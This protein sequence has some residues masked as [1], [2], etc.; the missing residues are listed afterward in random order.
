[1]LKNF[2]LVQLLIF[3]SPIL[4]YFYIDN[5]FLIWSLIELQT[6]FFVLYVWNSTLRKENLIFFLLIQIFSSLGIFICIFLKRWSSFSIILNYFFLFFLI[7]KMGLMP[8]HQW[9]FRFA[10][11]LDFAGLFL[12]LGI[13][14]LIPLFLIIKNNNEVLQILFY[15]NII[16]SV[17][18]LFK[19][20]RYWS[21]IFFSSIFLTSL[22]FLILDLFNFSNFIIIV[23]IYNSLSFLLIKELKLHNIK[24]VFRM[25]PFNM[26]L[27]LFFIIIRILG[28]P[29]SLGFLLKILY[30]QTITAGTGLYIRLIFLFIGSSILCYHYI[31]ILYFYFI[32]SGVFYVNLIN[33]NTNS[34]NSVNMFLILGALITPLFSFLGSICLFYLK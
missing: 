31:K 24:Y 17:L 12:F 22:I 32:T 34:K 10:N 28:I 27:S 33:V 8:F 2:F 6:L 4:L 20:N 14:K 7:V 25:F 18:I 30:L 16:F 23:L 29:Y 3:I 13:M 5:F 26:N 11:C 1:M 21:V 15:I 19:F 9:A